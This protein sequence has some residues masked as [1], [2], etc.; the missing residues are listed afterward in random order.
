MSPPPQKLQ[1]C[2][3]Q[4]NNCTRFLKFLFIRN[5]EQYY[6]VLLPLSCV[7]IKCTRGG[8]FKEENFRSIKGSEY[9]VNFCLKRLG[10]SSYHKSIAILLPNRGEDK[11]FNDIQAYNRKLGKAQYNVK[12]NNHDL[13]FTN[14]KV[15]VN[16]FSLSRLRKAVCLG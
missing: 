14:T 13:P 5:V 8:D 12:N 7:S 11:L 4:S 15:C 1:P 3:H 6:V 9:F 10:L 16:C 2:L